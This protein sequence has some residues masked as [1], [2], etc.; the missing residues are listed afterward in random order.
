MDARRQEK[1]FASVAPGLAPVCRSELSALGCSD[2]QL[3]AGGVEFSGKLSD[4]YRANLWLRSASRVV[5]R[6]ARMRCRSFP[7]LYRAAAKLPWGRFLRPGSAPLFRVTCRESRLMHSGRVAETLQAALAHALG[8]VPV[9]GGRQ[10]LLLVRVVNDEVE[11]S[12]DSSGELLHRRGYRTAVAAAPLRETLAAGILQRLAWDGRIPLADPLCGTGTFLLEGWSLACGTAPGIAR[13]FAFMD[14][15]GYRPGLWQVLCADAQR[16]VRPCAVAISGGDADAVALA[17]AH[18]NLERLDP[19][20]GVTLAHLPLERQPVHPGAGLVV[21]NPPYGKRLLADAPLEPYFATLGRELQ[22]AYPAWRKALLVPAPQLA[23][24]TG[25]RLHE[26][27][28][29]D[30]GGL[31][32]G[33]YATP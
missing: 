12:V 3:V 32:V 6:L 19:G 23:R 2:L 10:P 9:A 15:P 17:A 20:H 11:I 14:W 27:A 1:F 8:G 18:A 4:L 21:C 13:D 33:L 26:V 29:L 16:S 31:R 22:R 30:N 28:V 24:A 25:L 7:D 5:V